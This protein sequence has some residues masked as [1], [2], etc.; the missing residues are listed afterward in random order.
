MDAPSRTIDLPKDAHA[1]ARGEGLAHFDIAAGVLLTIAIAATAFA[2]RLI[3][4][5]AIASP[6]IIAVGIGI[7][8]NAAVGLPMWARAGIAFVLRGYCASRSRCSACS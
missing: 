6:M 4:G 8:I 5:L 7:A 2:L 1:A 3:P